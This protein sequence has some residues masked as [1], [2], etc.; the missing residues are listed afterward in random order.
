MS[1]HTPGPWHYEVRIPRG[2]ADPEYVV[3][4][5]N[6][7]TGKKGV[8][9]AGKHFT[10]THTEDEADACLIAAAPELLEALKVALACHESDEGWSDDFAEGA[11][12]AIAKAEG[13]EP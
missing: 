1:A 11:R 8:C 12:A 10:V 4:G 13:R 6:P 9:Y 3:L 5:T 7:D 2:S